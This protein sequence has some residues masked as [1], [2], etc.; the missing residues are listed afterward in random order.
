MLQRVVKDERTDPGK[1]RTVKVTGPSAPEKVQPH[2]RR[3]GKLC[4]SGETGR[5]P[6]SPWISRQ[7]Q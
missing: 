4:A 2:A 5:I 7:F 1:R 6:C 3:A